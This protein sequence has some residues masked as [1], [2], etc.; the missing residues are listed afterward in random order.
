[1][2]GTTVSHYRIVDSLGGGG[3][4]VVYK[5]ED[6]D[7]GRFVALKFLPD[8]VAHDAQ[9]LERFRREARAAS[10][11]NHPNICTIYEIGKHGEKLFIAM[12]FLDGMTLKHRIAGKPIETDVLVGLAIEIAD[13]LDAA[14][15]KG[16]VHRDIKP[17]NIY[18]TARG[19]AKILDFGLAKLTTPGSRPDQDETATIAA[20]EHQ[21]LTAPGAV[22]GT[23]AYMSPEQASGKELDARTDL[24]SFGAV[25]YEMATGTS[26]FR[27]ESAAVMFRN[28]LDCTPTPAVRLNPDLPPELERTIDKALEKERSLRYQSAA[29]MRA[30]LERLRRDSQSQSAATTAKTRTVGAKQAKRWLLP[31]WALLAVAAIAAG[32]YGYARSTRAPLTE[33]DTIVLADFTNSTGD[34]VFDG[35]L[36]EGMAVQL[37]QSPFLSL[38]SDDRIQQVLSLM[39][40]PAES[41][42]TPEIAREICER[43]ASAALLEGSIASLGTQYV[44][45]LRATDCRTQ[46]VLAEQ[47]VQAARKE[48][49]L[50]V[51]SNIASRF[52]TQMGESLQTVQEHNKPLEE[53]TTSSLEALKAYSV[54]WQVISAKGSTAGLPLLQRVIE[55]DPKFAMAHAVMGRLY[56]DL[57]ENDRSMASATIAYQLRDR[58]SDRER[59]F[60]EASYQIVV[61]GNLEKA[62]QTCLVWTQT[63]PRDVSAHGFL[64]G[65]V[66]AVS[67]RFD[68][69]LDEAQK[70][71]AA[72]P[73]FAIAYAVL[74]FSNV[75][76]NRIEDAQKA[77]DTAAERKLDLPDFLVARYQL[78][79]LK[80]DRAG[81]EQ[82]VARS[83]GRPGGEDWVAGFGAFAAA[84]SGHL[85]RARN[86]S[87][88]A[89]DIA[90]QASQKDRAA[91][92]AAAAALREA[93]F[94]NTA[95]ARQRAAA[96]LQLSNCRESVYGAAVALE[97]AGD[98][99]QAQK[100]G[101][102][103]QKRFPEDTEVRFTYVPVLRA[104]FALDHR[105]PAKTI[106]LLK[107]TVPYELGSPVASFVAFYG[108]LYPAYLRG[109][110][111]LAQRRGPEAAAEFQKILDHRGI[112]LADP[113]GALAHL[114]L[115]RAYAMA[116]DAA[117][118]KAAYDEFL[119]LWKD[120]DP[121]IPVLE[122]ARAEYAKL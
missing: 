106:D 2:I 108:P 1:M 82:D 110:A 102:D 87:Q 74:D 81:M 99:A 49:V 121:G 93:L 115:G 23:V 44:L 10:A 92:F 20:M 59:F 43:T 54:A 33:K 34:A 79:F 91:Q 27:G 24:F 51:L 47:Q 32:V 56:G 96:A 68:Q 19:H 86:L 105:D 37:E 88:H 8:D 45:G 70:M 117:K 39:G 67:G 90:Q 25:L 42:L 113:V 21:Q 50:K 77:M 84:Y 30:D 17:A 16:I 120:A 7:L 53:A 40:K 15:S 11:L 46:H 97:L 55:M 71:V 98:S 83:K 9:A 38:I 69:A 62:E 6:T 13:A 118:A 63:Y 3:M 29:E 122:Q 35:T 36:R 64:A 5:A 89:I 114:Q 94:G 66:Y 103:L 22:I 57:G 116:G 41:R 28:I 72:D 101:E 100:L 18:V 76:L 80:G 14:H 58:T 78:A 61:T 73:D 48:D 119:T 52:R 104:Q 112:V 65:T 12:E 4:G 31:A 85:D 75:S 95:A 60:I 109:E 107:S 111:Y 26:P